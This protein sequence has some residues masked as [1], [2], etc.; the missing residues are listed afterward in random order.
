MRESKGKHVKQPD[1]KEGEIIY[2]QLAQGMEQTRHMV[3][4]SIS[5]ASTIS[6]KE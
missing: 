1:K 6:A 4:N 2:S 5:R 3:R